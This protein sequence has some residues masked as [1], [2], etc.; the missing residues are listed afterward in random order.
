M[1]KEFSRT[2]RVAQEIQREL[3]VLL[4]REVK[5]PR[6]TMAT[7]SAVKVSKDLLNANVFVTFMGQ[8]TPQQIDQAM[9]ALNKMAGFLRSMLA[10]R[11]RMRVLPRLQFKFD[12]SLVQGRRMSS[13]IDLAVASDQARRDDAIYE[14][15]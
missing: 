10:Q 8:D 12:E 15:E 5:D 13:L 6:V 7:V 2:D 14:E 1:A 3:A 9:L 11:I 4:Q